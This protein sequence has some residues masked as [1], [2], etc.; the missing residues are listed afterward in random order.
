MT[1]FGATGTPEV[2]I[3]KTASSFQIRKQLIAQAESIT[4]VEFERLTSTYSYPQYT[5]GGLPKFQMSGAKPARITPSTSQK[6]LRDSKS[7]S[8]LL[9]DIQSALSTDPLFDDQLKLTDL[10]RRAD[11]TVAAAQ[12]W[13]DAPTFMNVSYEDFEA[14]FPDRDFLVF[15]Y[16][17]KCSNRIWHK[18]GFESVSDQS[19]WDSND[20]GT[21]PR[22]AKDASYAA[23]LY[24]CI[25]G[26]FGYSS[27]WD[28]ATPTIIP[29]SDARDYFGGI[30]YRFTSEPTDD[31]NSNQFKI[32]GQEVSFKKFYEWQT[33]SGNSNWK[34][35][36][37]SFGFGRDRLRF[38][39]ESDVEADRFIEAQ[40]AERLPVWVAVPQLDCEGPTKKLVNGQNHPSRD[41]QTEWGWQG[42]AADEGTP[43]GNWQS[44]PYW[45]IKAPSRLYYGRLQDMFLLRRFIQYGDHKRPNIQGQLDGTGKRISD[46]TNVETILTNVETIFLNAR[47]WYSGK[48]KQQL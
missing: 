17:E 14:E 2:T 47:N 36:K 18:M 40:E 6:Y 43:M 33:N 24:G 45:A 46:V 31:G 10:I 19:T 16:G 28:A 1:I 22:A 27:D 48:T 30:A 3:D 44:K 11:K 21:L 20:L 5:P 29:T 13:V 38:G 26:W 42:E 9:E 32:G 4:K 34:F 12:Q 25:R 7:W 15:T 8:G 39:I 35:V 23:K 37:L 41:L